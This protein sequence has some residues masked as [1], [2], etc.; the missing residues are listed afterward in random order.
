MFT[1]RQF[2]SDDLEAVRKLFVDGQRQFAAGFET[3]IESYIEET[4]SRDLADVRAHYLGRPGSNFWVVEGDGRLVGTAGLQRRNEEEAELRR[5]NVAIEYRRRG[6]AQSLLDTVEEYARTQG[7][8]RL[9][10][11]TIIPLVPAIA[12]YEKNGFRRTGQHRYGS[13][14]VLHFSKNLLS[15]QGRPEGGR[16]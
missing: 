11:S 8:S 14:T 7:Y 1:I 4:L 9:L 10:L 16:S 2:R 15:G 5:M 6:I 12:M 3:E 13:V